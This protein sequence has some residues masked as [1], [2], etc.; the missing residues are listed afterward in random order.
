MKN[1]SIK[2]LFLLFLLYSFGSQAMAQCDWQ[3]LGPDDFL[4]S[5]GISGGIADYLD[6][7]M[8]G[9]TPYVVYRDN[10]NGDKVTVKKYDG[11]NWAT[12]GNAGLSIGVA[13]YISIA[14]DG[15]GTPYVAYRDAGYSNLIAVKKFTGSSWQTVGYTGLSNRSQ[16]GYD[17]HIAIAPNGE[18]YVTW[19]NSGF[20]VE[21]YNG[22]YWVTVG[23]QNVEYDE[24]NPYCPWQ[25]N[26]TR[27]TVTVRASRIAFD[28]NGKPYVSYLRN[29]E[30]TRCSDGS[31]YYSARVHVRELDGNT[32][33]Y[34]GGTLVSTSGSSTWDA[35]DVYADIAVAPD[36]VPYVV[37][38]DP[39]ENDKLSV[40]KF[41]GSSWVTVGN[42]GFS[43]GSA[44]PHTYVRPDISISSDGT[45]IVAYGYNSMSVM[46]YQAGNWVN[47]GSSGFSASSA[48]YPSI[49]IGDNGVIYATYRGGNE[50]WSKWYPT[51]SFTLSG[52][53]QNIANGDHI[54]D[55]TD[56]TDFGSSITIDTITRTFTITNNGS[57]ALTISGVNI[58]G[59]DS[60]EFFIS[61]NPAASIAAGGSTTF[62]I[63]YS[64]RNDG[65][66]NAFI[67]VET[68]DCNYPTY[69][70]AI[71][72]EKLIPAGA[73]HLDGVNDYISCSKRLPSNG[74]SWSLE[75]WA[76]PETVNNGGNGQLLFGQLSYISSWFSS[77]F[78]AGSFRVMERNGF[79][80]AI[81][82][83][84]VGAR[85]LNL[86][87]ATAN[88]WTHLAFSYDASTQDISAYK[89]GVLE[90]VG[91]TVNITPQN[92]I[93]RSSRMGYAVSDEPL[94]FRG[95]IDE[96]R[97]WDYPLCQRE[98]ELRKNCELTGSEMGLQT[99]FDFNNTNATYL[100]NN[101]GQIS[102]AEK[103]GNSTAAGLVNFALTG[104]NSNWTLQAST[105]SD[106]SCG[107]VYCESYWTGNI[108]NDWDEASNWMGNFKPD[109]DDDAIIPNGAPNYPE[110]EI[111]AEIN[112]ISIESN[113]SV[114]ILNGQSLTVNGVLDNEG[115]FT[116]ESG[117]ALVQGT[118]STLAGSGTY[119]VERNIP[120][121][122]TFFGSPISNQAV[123]GFGI[124]ATG[125]NGGQVEPD[126]SNPCN[127]TSVDP[128]SPYGN[129]MEVRED[130]TPISNCGQ[131]LW[132]V[133]S[134]GSLDNG[135]GYVVNST[136]TTLDFS[137]TVN[138][139]AI[140][141][142]GL[143]RQTGNI[144]TQDGSNI[145]MGWH[146]V[147]NPYPSP[148]A[149]SSAD[150]L[151]MGFDGQI[152]LYN[153]VSGTWVSYIN[154]T[155][156]IAVG[157]GF[158]IRK[159]NVGGTSDFVLD[160]TYRTI[161]NPQYYKQPNSLSQA[162]NITLDNGAVI[163]QHQ[164][165]FIN[166]ATEHF[167]PQYDAN[168]LMGVYSNPLL[169]TIA[170]SQRL[171]YNAYAPMQPEEEK[172]VPLGVHAG[173]DGRFTLQFNGIDDLEAD[174][175]LEDLQLDTT[176]SLTEAYT[177]A[178]TALDA[179]MNERFLLH[180]HKHAAPEEPQDTSS[181]QEEEVISSID[182]VDTENIVLFPNPTEANITLKLNQDHSYNKAVV[183]DVTGKEKLSMIVS[184]QAN[185]Y[186]L[187]TAELSKGVYFL[188]LS[189][190]EHDTT[191]KFIKQ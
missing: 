98:I 154:T 117:A 144:G 146:L 168:K 166:G 101:S 108:N 12:V 2:K 32:W 110:I 45:P 25:T 24:N 13:S 31:R 106:T 40:K 99:Y 49:G 80:I 174:V 38:R 148:I 167:D 124:A 138:N 111:D 128:N 147:A 143:T 181:I 85:T 43:S 160:N 149:L 121:P 107:P 153:S 55:L 34:T 180:F 169:Y 76:N 90:A 57:S 22:R 58:T 50:V 8:Y 187:N 151:A 88:E 157:Q 16:T 104:A 41:D 134:V 125:T 126:A 120:G 127:P 122:Q 7:A 51:S 142:T 155:V 184:Q 100:G 136:A 17:I 69:D 95:E 96:V 87:T 36:N 11:S 112:H 21:R 68:N 102:V 129:I 89:N 118:G 64:T 159:T 114:H 62:E 139:G 23:N 140:T 5:T 165:Y 162:L 72:G 145:T 132:F 29:Y 1:T 19:R 116:I 54:P 83:F 18:P 9:N 42:R 103:S 10:T 158:Q 33:V 130:A 137:G 173:A 39:S 59:A 44:G 189:G 152:N 183:Y 77:Y 133:K 188:R 81:L 113:A 94:L 141:Y 177:Y 6:M 92:I 150:L 74:D 26:S 27:Y 52:N 170:D 28:S 119:H 91:S 65:I 190:V 53:G 163:D 182:Q 84:S 20:Y 4:V 30:S 15:S 115:T 60:A 123:G 172:T 97:V 37:Y 3:A 185:V 86:G 75:L 79:Y 82:D 164:L 191:L 71:T 70:F 186:E 178:F 161:G 61:A 171:S 66:H 131:S 46:K 156:D 73:I 105:M 175:W 176:V 35:E 56:H 63:S 48:H 93:D 78:A 179:D 135:R 47:V 67:E 109:T 14:V